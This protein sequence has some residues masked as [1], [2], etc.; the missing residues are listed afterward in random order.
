M[1]NSTD[2]N[3]TIVNTRRKKSKNGAVTFYPPNTIKEKVGE[4]GIDPAIINLAQVR[5]NA[6]KIDFEPYAQDFLGIIQQNIL[7]LRQTKQSNFSR[8]SAEIKAITDAI[9]NI[10]SNSGM[11]HYVLLSQI[12]SSAL[13][14][15]ENINI[16]NNASLSLIDIYY[17]TMQII[18]THE[19]LGDGSRYGKSLIDELSYACHRYHKKYPN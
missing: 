12:A 6:I 14:F 17:K 10:K 15:I 2:Q 16:I 19:I 3:L 13:N 9:M 4:G 11:F 1:K 18:V 5:M 8:D 7:L